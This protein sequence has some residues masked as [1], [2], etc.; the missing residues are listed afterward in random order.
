MLQ[1][2]RDNGNG[3]LMP[4]W[5]HSLRQLCEHV[6]NSESTFANFAYLAEVK[7]SAFSYP[8]VFFLLEFEPWGTF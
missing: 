3:F 7:A 5:G 4:P 6:H 2:I 1:Q 8:S